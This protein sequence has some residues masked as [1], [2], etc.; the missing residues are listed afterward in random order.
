MTTDMIDSVLPVRALGPV[1][2]VS[3]LGFGAMGMSEFYGPSDD[4]ASAALLEEVCERGVT[5]I[6]TADIY[7][8][9]HNESLIRTLLRSRRTVPPIVATKCGI[10]RSVSPRRID[11]TPAYVRRCCEASLARLDV[12][13][14]DLYYLHRID[15]AADIEATMGCLA[16]LVR[17]GKIAHV[18]L[19]EVSVPTLVRAHRVHPVAAVQT[20]YSLWSR[21]AQEGILAAT[22][23][24]GIGLVAYSPLGRGFLTGRVTSTAQLAPGDFRRANPRFQEASLAHNLTLLDGVQ[25]VAARHD[26]SAAQV[27]LAWLLAQGPH[28]VPIPGTRNARYLRDNLAALALVLTAEDL[29]LLDGAPPAMG[30]RYLEEGMLGIGA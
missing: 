21:D 26:A 9:G 25:A 11:N 19:C 3:A 13:R 12:E 27:A 24:L 16:D 6:D 15:P 4:A 18:G 20:E 30:A 1:L 5:L 23:R 29:A 22:A 10:D 17:E 7:G 14:I 8:N 28:V 2:A